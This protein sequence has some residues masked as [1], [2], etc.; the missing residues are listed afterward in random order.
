MNE[1]SVKMLLNKEKREY[2][3][4]PQTKHIFLS[5]K[6]KTKTKFGVILHQ[7][8]IAVH[9]EDTY[10]S[11]KEFTVAENPQEVGDEESS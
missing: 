3:L 1:A 4:L 7:G 5:L 8:Q 9:W 6:K 11:P 2:L 10:T